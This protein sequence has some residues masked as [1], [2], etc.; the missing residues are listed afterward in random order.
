M[1]RVWKAIPTSTGTVW[2][3]PC[4][5]VRQCNQS[6]SA[7]I[8]GRPQHNT[9]RNLIGRMRLLNRSGFLLPP[10]PPPPPPLLFNSVMPAL[11][12]QVECL[13]P[14]KSNSHRV[15]RYPVLPSLLTASL[16]PIP[17]PNLLS[18]HPHF[19]VPIS[20]PHNTAGFFFFFFFFP[21]HS[22]L[23]PNGI[24]WDE[25]ACVSPPPPPPPPFPSRPL[26]SLLRLTNRG[27]E[28]KKKGG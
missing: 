19:S 26:F 12:R 2:V 13:S 14:G 24:P 17:T 22:S 27:A 1:F 23:Q 5:N 21:L 7:H 4:P 11:Y 15:A 8:W 9:D 3:D 6:P 16:P 20:N 18:T 28:N 25:P 10:P